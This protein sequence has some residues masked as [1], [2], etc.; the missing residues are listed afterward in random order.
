MRDSSENWFAPSSQMAGTKYVAR[1][2]GYVGTK[3]PDGDIVARKVRKGQ[4]TIHV[5]VVLDVVSAGHACMLA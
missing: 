4:T 5:E 2:E 3:V 1:N